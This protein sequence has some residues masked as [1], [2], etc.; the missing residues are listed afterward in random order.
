M[1]ENENIGE[2]L[3]TQKTLELI[4]ELFKGQTVS[5]PDIVRIVDGEWLKRGGSKSETKVHPATNALARLKRNGL[6]DNPKLGEWRVFDETAP[7]IENGVKQIGS[8]KSSVY[9]Y[10]YPAYQKLA[11]LEGQDTWAC[12]VGQS[13]YADP[14]HRINDQTTGMPETPKVALVIRTNRP[15]EMES[16]IHGVLSRVPDAPGTEWFL[17]NPDKVES[18]YNIIMKDYH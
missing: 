10:Y 8:G 17:T 18:I 15:K 2:P 12:K 1:N 7:V 3:S 13:E 4:L 5:K 9:V 11:Q 14:I 16:A 6:A